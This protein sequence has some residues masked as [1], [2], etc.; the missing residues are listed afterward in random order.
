MPGPAWFPGTFSYHREGA[1]Q[2]AQIERSFG[3]IVRLKRWRGLPRTVFGKVYLV[4]VELGLALFVLL[5]CYNWV[6]GG[7]SLCYLCQ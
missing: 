1:S 4:L 2:M 6:M 3:R 7:F 5:F